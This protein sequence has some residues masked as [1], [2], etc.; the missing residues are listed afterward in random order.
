MSFTISE[1]CIASISRSTFYNLRKQGHAPELIY[2]GDLPRITVEAD[3]GWQKACEA[4]ARRANATLV[5]EESV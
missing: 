2:V 3:A 5:H 4:R 1:W